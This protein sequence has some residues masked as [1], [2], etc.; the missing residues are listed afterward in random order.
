[1]A[2][3]TALAK[4]RPGRKEDELLVGS[5]RTRNAALVA[6]FPQF[7]WADRELPDRA[8]GTC[9]DRS[10]DRARWPLIAVWS[11]RP[12]DQRLG[13]AFAICRCFPRMAAS[14]GL[15]GQIARHSVGWRPIGAGFCVRL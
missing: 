11:C 3:W 4:K 14:T 2:W 12:P 6:Q 9:S 8:T 15:C 1:M 10:G 13:S 7:G 5:C